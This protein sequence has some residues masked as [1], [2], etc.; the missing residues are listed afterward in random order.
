MKTINSF[1][2]KFFALVLA[3]VASVSTFAQAPDFK[4]GELYYK[5]LEGDTVEVTYRQRPVL[6]TGDSTATPKKNSEGLGYENFTEVVIPSM[7]TYED[8]TY[9]VTRIGHGTFWLCDKLTY[10]DIPNTIKSMMFYTL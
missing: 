6:P 10:V 1:R 7:I 2:S 4:V 3:L 9:H 5:V 8:K